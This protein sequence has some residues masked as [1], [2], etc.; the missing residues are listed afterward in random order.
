[1]NGPDLTIVLELTTGDITGVCDVRRNLTQWLR[2][3]ETIAP[4]PAEVLLVGPDPPR[5]L[6]DDRGPGPGLRFV[7]VPGTGYYGLKNAG[8]NEARGAVVLFSDLD[9]RPGPGY[10]LALLEAF[11]DPAVGGVAGRSVYDGE[12]LLSR[13]NSANS[14]GD[15]HAGPEAFERA[16][17]LAHNV[18]LRRELYVRS[19]WGP[20]VGRIGG[21]GYLT[22]L[23]RRSGRRLVL[24]ERLLVRHEDPS[25][26]LRGSVERHLRDTFVPLH[27]GTERQRFSAAF[28]LACALALR[29]GLR[30]RRVWRAGPRLGLRPAH[31]PAIAAVEA[32]YWAFDLGLTLA[33]LGIPPLRRRWLAFLQPDAL[34]PPGGPG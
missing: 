18:S 20:F 8:A 10:A 1:V 5:G 19:P 4:R 25:R 15:L 32:G 3:V 12:G 31:V 7:H 6:P 17:A 28:T 22:S 33:V 24:D 26:S 14:F 23:V 27:Y 2:E 11:R 30:L 16:M 13:I 21:D 34:P 9:C 29:L